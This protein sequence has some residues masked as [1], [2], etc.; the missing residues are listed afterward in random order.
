MDVEAGVFPRVKDLDAL[1]REEFLPDQKVDDFGAEEFFEGLERGVRQG[2]EGGA[3]WRLQAGGRW[4][5][6][7]A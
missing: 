3:G 4:R 7:R 1:R 6:G 2:V 5:G